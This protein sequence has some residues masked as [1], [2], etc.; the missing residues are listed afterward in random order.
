MQKVDLLLTNAGQLVTCASEGRPK[1]GEQMRDVGMIQNGAVAV[2]DGKIIAGG[3]TDEITAQYESGTVID[4]SGKAV[5]P[6]FVDC[7]TH[8]VYAGSRLDEFEMRIAGKSYLEIMAAGGGIASTVKATRSASEDELFG[9][10]FKR[11]DTMLELGTT[12]AEIKTGYGLDVA[13]EMKILHVIEALEKEHPVRIVPTFLGAHAIPPEYKGRSQAYVEVVL[14][15]I[16]EA[17]EWYQNSIFAEENKPF[18]NDVFTEKNAFNVQQSQ[19]VLEVGKELGM[20][21]KAHVDEF[22]DLGGVAMAVGLGAVS[23]DHLDVTSEFDLKQLALTNTVGVV[24]PIVNMNLGSTHFANARALIDAN[25]ILALATDINPGSAPS[26]SMPI[27]MSIAT[28]YQKLLPAEALNASTINAAFAIGMGA[29]V[30]SIETGK[31]A[32]M[33]ILDTHDYRDMIYQIGG[34]LVETVILGGEIIQ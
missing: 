11:L 19:A 5:V 12:T 2:Q 6:G 23:V 33:L 16:V 24:L 9:Q 20:G 30:G 17:I 26:P 31:Y 14:A 21:V 7:H 32:D 29:S 15:M 13:T 8:V 3:S 25:G 1:R 22:T 34:N 27:T 10:S 4:A 18:F 28:R